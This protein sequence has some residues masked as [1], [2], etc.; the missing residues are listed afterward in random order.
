M[1]P[2][3]LARRARILIAE[4]ESGI[5]DTLS[6][7]LHADGDEPIWCATAGEA[8][9]QFQATLPAPVILDVGLPAM[10]GFGLY[11]R[12]H[13][14]PGAGAVPFLGMERIQDASYCGWDGSS[15]TGE[16]L[17]AWRAAATQAKLADRT[18]VLDS[19]RITTAIAANGRPAATQAPGHGSFDNDVDVLT[20]TLV[21]IRGG[22]KLLLPVDDLRGY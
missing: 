3:A 21:R 10:N 22:K 9:A 18:T 2:S 20:R 19:E 6:Y 11:R 13:A 12:L 4:D 16:A 14:L 7:V 5:A 8:L 15:D 1:H 17:A